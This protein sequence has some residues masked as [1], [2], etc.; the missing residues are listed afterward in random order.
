MRFFQGKRNGVGVA[1]MSGT[2]SGTELHGI[3]LM[4][5]AASS[6]QAGMIARFDDATFFEHIDDGSMLNRGKAMRDD[7]GGALAHELLE[8]LLHTMF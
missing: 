6:K 7:E 4:V 1:V 8:R 3:K 2:F 5:A